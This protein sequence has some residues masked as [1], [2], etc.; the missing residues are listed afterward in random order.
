MALRCY[1]RYAIEPGMRHS[2]LG[3]RCAKTVPSGSTPPADT[4][5]DGLPDWW[6]NWY[7][8][9]VEA[10]DPSGDPDADGMHNWQEY[11]AGTDPTA[12]GSLLR[13]DVVSAPPDFQIRWPSVLGR[14]YTVERSTNAVNY[15][16]IGVDILA[17][18][19]VN[20]YSD[21]PPAAAT[22]FYRVMVQP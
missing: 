6:E 21:S 2:D 19:P 14:L 15:A 8:S 20:I 11:V 17:T 10:C 18:P 12:A 16:A 9:S 7:F 3:F 5:G 22:Y 1:V 13:I 4:D